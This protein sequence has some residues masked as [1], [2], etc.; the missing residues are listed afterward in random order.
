MPKQKDI[1]TTGEVAKICNV[2]PR[3]VSKWFDSGQLKGYRI[4]GSKD[5][6]IPLTAL[7]KFMKQHQIP[8]DGLQSGKTRVLLV[9]E[10][11]ETVEVLK[12]MLVEQ[13]GYEVDL[14]HSGFSAGVECEKFRPHV[15][16]I[17]LHLGDVSG[18]D[19]LKLVRENPDLQMSKVIAVSGKLTEGQASALTTAGFDG[20]LRKPFH[21]KQV[22]DIVEEATALVY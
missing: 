2:A 19:V 5:R 3:T 14:A 20:F 7:I 12:K 16:L 21:V 4:P 17:D 13:A 22:I 9:D 8:L 18:E 10:V 15:I 1:L 6:R 11:S